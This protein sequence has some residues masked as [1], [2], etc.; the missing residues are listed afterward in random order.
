M[1]DLIWKKS[2]NTKLSPQDEVKFQAWVAEQSKARGRDMSNDDID[3][4]LRGYWLNG[5]YKAKADGHM[6]DTYKKP[7]HPTFSNESKY[8]GVPDPLGG[9]FTGGSWEGND[10]SGWTFKPTLHMLNN[11][12]QLEDLKRYMAKY[13]KGVKL[14]LPPPYRSL[15]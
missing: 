4:D 2:Y 6:P 15:Q 7:N 11:T 14:V 5:G 1:G 9:K 10:K 13:E 12:H 3:Y 8:H